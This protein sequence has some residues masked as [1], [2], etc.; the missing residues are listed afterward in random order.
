RREQKATS[1]RAAR[2]P[3][4]DGDANVPFGECARLEIV[5]RRVDDARPAAEIVRDVSGREQRSD[6]GERN[7]NDAI[8]R[9][10]RAGAARSMSTQ[11]RERQP[12]AGGDFRP[13]V[14]R[15]SECAERRRHR[16]S[17]PHAWYTTTSLFSTR[18]STGTTPESVD[19]MSTAISCQ[20][21]LGSRSYLVD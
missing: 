9:R 5:A 14:R 10:G 20:A 1:K 8:R 17:T 19:G 18:I 21:S 4:G 6:D 11:R 2:Q 3:C 13:R 16:R 15:S 12:D 7:H